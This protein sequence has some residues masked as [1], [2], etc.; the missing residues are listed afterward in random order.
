V[1]PVLLLAL[2]AALPVIITRASR[3][4]PPTIAAARVD[5][6]PAENINSFLLTGADVS[7][8]KTVSGT[9][10]PGGSIAYT[11]LLSN[12]GLSA[13]L[14][15]TGDEFTDVLPAGL[16]LVSAM[17]TSGTVLT[18]VNTVTWNGSIPASGSVTITISANINGDA[19]GTTIS[20][21]GSIAYDADVN[22]TNEANRVTDD[23]S[24]GAAN[25]PTSFPV[26]CAITVTNLNDSGAGSLRQAII[27]ANS[28]PCTDPITFQPGLIGTITL[29][30]TLPDLSTSMSILGPGA[31]KVTV[32]GN[33]LIRVFNVTVTNPGGVTLSG[34]TIANGN[35]GGNGGGILL[36]ST[37][38]INLTESVLSDN[39]GSGG[40]GIYNNSTGA[41]N[42]GNS[43]FNNNAAG[44]GGGGIYNLL[45][46]AITI[47][48]STFSLNSTAGSSF[49]G[50]IYNA[51]NGPITI[52][53]STFSNNSGNPGN[54]GGIANSNGT[55]IIVNSTFSNNS[56][57]GDGGG[58]LNLGGGAV[59][60]RNTIIALNTAA[61]S[62]PD[63]NGMFTSN[64]HNLI[65]NNSGGTIAPASGDLIGTN[66]LPVNPLLGPLQN[67]GG[68]TQTRALLAG[69][70]A[71]DAGDDCVTQLSGCLEPNITTDQRG[72]G[73]NRSVDG[74]DL[75]LTAA[76]DIGAFE[77]QVSV[78]DITDKT[79]N[80]DTQL[81]FTFNIGGTAS[82]VTATSANTALVPNNPANIAVTGSGSTRTLTIN[83]VANQFGTSTITVTVSDANSQSMSDTF[84]L[85]VN[86]IADTPSVT[87]ATTN[88]DTQ[89]SSGLVI[90]RNA[91]DGAEVTHFK[92]TSITNGTL[93]KTGAIQIN[94]GDF[95][96][97][98]EGNAG[99]KFM[100][101]ANLFSP[102][103]TFSF[104]IQGATS[105][106]GAGLSS[107]FAT[108]T[109]TVNTIADTP[110]VT[111]ATTTV[112]TQT[113]SGLVVSRNAAD[114][115]EVTNFKITAITNGTL[116]KNN[117]T[118]QINSGDFITIAEGNA[119][120]KFT[121]A[122]NLSS[123]VTTFNF[124]VQAST[125]S[126]NAGLGGSTATATITVNCGSS[127]VTT[128]TDSGAGSL[129]S[130]I[131]AACPGSTITF[132]MNQVTSP[133]TLTSGELLLNKS[134]TFQ[135][136]GANLLTI[137]RSAAPGT[138]LFSIF[139]IFDPSVATNLSGLT[140]SN[141]DSSAN[142]GAIRNSGALTVNGVTLSNNHTTAGG[143]AIFNGGTGT[144][145][146][147]NS[148][149]S[150]N[151]SDILAAI[152]NQ[153]GT[154]T[155]TNSTLSANANLGNLPGTAVFSESNSVINLTNCTVSQNTG[156]SV[157]V[158]QNAGGTGQ[159]NLKNTIVSGNTGGDV[160]NITN[161]GNNLIGGSALLGPLANNGGP[162]QTMA[163]LAGSPALDAGDNCVLTNACTPAL[164]FSLTTDQRGAGFAR[165]VDGP[166][167]DTTA[168]VDIGAFEAQL[169]VEDITDK[170]TNEDTQ[171]QFT[172]NV[173][174]AAASVT[175]T[176]G[177]TSL[178]PNNA[179]NIAVTGSGSTRTLTINPAANLFGTSTITVTV[180]GANSQSMTDTF[181]LT[182]NPVADTPSVTNAT[183]SVNTQTTSGLV[184]S[185]HPADDAEV[186]N[187]KITNIQNGTL[188]KNNGTTQ[189]NNNDFI[190]IADGSAGLKFT[191][192]TNLASPGTT[193]SFQ[194]QASTSSSNAG[195]GGSTATAT[196]TVNGSLV[197][198]SSA[199]YNTTESSFAAT[200][201]V[202]RVG[203]LTSTVTV[204]YATPD[205][206]AATPPV[207]PCATAGLVSSRCDFTTAVGT[208]RF[209]PGESS[210]T[211]PV[212][213]SQ[214][215]FVEGPENLPLTL[216]NVSPNSMLG[217][218]SLAT[219][220]I[221]D[222][223]TE[224]AA[225]P[226]DDA[227]NFVRQHY[228]DFLNREPDAGGLAF[229]TKEIP[230]CAPNQVCVDAK[231]VNVSVAFFLSVEFQNT[232]YLVERI[233]KASYGDATGTSTLGGVHQLPV[234]IVKFSEFLPDMQTIGQGLIVGQPGWETVLEN[235]KQAFVAQFVQRARFTTAYANTLTP[236]QFVNLLFA[237]A[238]VIPTASE[239]QAAI[240]EFGGAGTSI[241]AAARGRALRRVAEN[242]ALIQ[243]EFNRALVLMQYFGYLRRNPDA[244]PDSDHSGYDFWLTK[245][246]QFTQ[247]G[248]DVMV[249]IQKAEMVK[250]FLLATE[251]RR[252][253]GAQFDFS[254]LEK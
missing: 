54:G 42:I 137:Q 109:I 163:L 87:N 16:T 226:I 83:P 15:N 70:P 43:T 55:L 225:N 244:A 146:L 99:L 194:V 61:G 233:Y 49:G 98:A 31:S 201:T 251:Y 179:A 223:V 139:S 149:L 140:L 215:N 100:P 123:P 147:S 29:S 48:N 167:A 222:D 4:A 77:A 135:G 97:F 71:L 39:V 155:I 51:S 1:L 241:N 68:L 75:D 94:N 38:T 169:A 209:G 30:S 44:S 177:N 181:V 56:A 153:G 199:T 52:T 238:G 91:V 254:E 246:N 184:I 231:R 144:V 46:G 212:L 180:N 150:G 33:G 74:P 21:Q 186:T 174:G 125:S 13:Q 7:G 208:L 115:A 37:G 130:T 200:I 159:V 189:I 53:N 152:Y 203:D 72:E 5:S 164:G 232:G 62:G 216:S 148:T 136:P 253:F 156:Q 84:V 45:S 32:S 104:Q 18:M 245:L 124:Q 172:F 101:A 188:F 64:G 197:R 248:D 96:T 235:N 196:I 126:S 127:I 40:G 17:A 132:D 116:F 103:T 243:Q 118:T 129:R 105:A 102:G 220:T 108:A 28:S 73:F 117:G 214:D 195:L 157:A 36:N 122:N 205:D 59:L 242:G 41:I 92:I 85:N 14:D 162:T 11:V 93:F 79:T 191:P 80:E 176:S 218:P 239:R 182:V 67:N 221:A 81:Q 202:E 26:S 141:A 90:S 207:L 187:F 63:V 170:A 12:S 237:N 250:A 134:L 58:I 175:A 128:N 47:T 142:G 76:V 82:S 252:R 106:G 192:A 213:I 65:G 66:A 23:P 228:H 173:G 183:T 2:A 86:A 112:N 204:D 171:L 89:T 111:N 168:T 120:L 211:F 178:V 193:F 217:S 10:V 20:N 121:P 143:S 50:G 69:S 34:L 154:F 113:G 88:E 35:T 247:P 3:P 6:A 230:P 22:G 145:T 229:W 160:S 151:R 60:L 78:E 185:R 166:D 210:K 234:P 27:D 8:T 161:N 240:D 110:S 95:I 24:T 131:N 227:T 25:D 224:P 114:G 165:S 9:F 190:T 57:T 138:A 158:Y 133:I 198:F 119:G 206:S 249:R 236:T 19:G 107:G 219:L